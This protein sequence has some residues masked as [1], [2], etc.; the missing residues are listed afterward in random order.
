MTAQEI[1]EMPINKIRT[2]AI[3][4]GNFGTSMQFK[5]MKEKKEIIVVTRQGLLKYLGNA[6]WAYMS[7][8]KN[9]DFKVFKN[10]LSASNYI[11]NQLTN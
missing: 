8:V 11:N 5:V 6:Q 3:K 4:V 9:K 10:E 7:G 2:I 1:K